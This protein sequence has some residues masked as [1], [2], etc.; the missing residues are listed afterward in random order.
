MVKKIVFI[1]D[2]AQNIDVAKAIAIKNFWNFQIFD[3][4]APDLLKNLE[5]YEPHVIFINDCSYEFNRFSMIQQSEILNRAEII[6]IVDLND[7]KTLDCLGRIERVEIINIPIRDVQFYFR[8]KA[9]L[10]RYESK[11][12]IEN[13]IHELKGKLDKAGKELLAYEQKQIALS[14][15]ATYGHEINNPLAIAI[16]MLGKNFEKLTPEKYLK[17]Q[18]ALERIKNIL[19]DMQVTINEKELLFDQYSVNSKK[20]K[21]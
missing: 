20:L 1:D 10:E 16:G 5:L 12:K 4:K 15:L 11:R 8:A 21:L 17:V 18:H 7:K 19:Q 14:M 9:A 6:L 13:L 3:R 2:N